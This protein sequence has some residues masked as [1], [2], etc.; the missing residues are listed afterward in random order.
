MQVLIPPAWH[1]IIRARIPH[2]RS[3]ARRG[4]E[5]RDAHEGLASAGLWG[6][7]PQRLAAATGTGVFA[8]S[9]AG[10]GASSPVKL[11]RPLDY[12]QIEALR[13]AAESS[14][15]HRLSP[16]RPA[17]PFRRA[18]IAGSTPVPSRIT[19][20]GRGDDRAD[21]VVEESRLKSIA[22]VKTA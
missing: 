4:A 9:R 19:E 20:F 15:C 16:R 18:S 10:Y 14:R 22:E 1:R 7:F 13:D 6:D 21:F 3:F 11:P 12:M 17:R 5:Y 8:Y 2:D